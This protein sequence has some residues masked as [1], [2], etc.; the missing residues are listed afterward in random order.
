MKS[1]TLHADTNYLA[2]PWYKPSAAWLEWLYQDNKLTLER[3]IQLSATNFPCG[4]ATRKRD[5]EEALRDRHKL[6][7]EALVARELKELA[8]EDA[9]QPLQTQSFPDVDMYIR[10]FK[11]SKRRRPV[12]LI[13]G[14]TGLGKSLMAGQILGKIGKKHGLF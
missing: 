10:S 14:A 2:G 9:L 5:V 7:V 3:F 8:D 12:L 6:E 13:L 1:G 11:R 4:H